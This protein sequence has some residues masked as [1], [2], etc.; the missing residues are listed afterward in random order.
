[1]RKK[2]KRA[3]QLERALWEDNVRHARAGDIEAARD[4]LRDVAESVENIAPFREPE[5]AR[6]GPIPWWY[7]EYLAQAFRQ[8]LNGVAPEKALNLVG[9][10][11]GRR[12]GKSV[13]HD[14]EAVAAAFHLL[15]RKQSLPDGLIVGGLKPEQANGELQRA[16]GVDR[17]TVYRA[18]RQNQ[19]F[20]Y[21]KWI[22]DE[23]LKVVAKPYAARI[24]AILEKTKRTR[25]TK[26][27]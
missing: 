7:A 8:I 1:M 26:T 27:R 14:L 10:K 17:A 18:R 15:I 20:Q 9:K 12:K 23:I 4:I 24:T 22:D 13:T 3:A 2:S 11:R 5:K 6:G 21:P 19:A 16:L 25:R